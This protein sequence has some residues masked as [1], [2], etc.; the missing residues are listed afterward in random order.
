MTDACILLTFCFSSTNAY[1]TNLS[2]TILQ[3]FKLEQN[4]LGYFFKIKNIDKMSFALKVY[5][6]AILV[7]GI[8]SHRIPIKN[9]W[10]N[11]G[12]EAWAVE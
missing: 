7:K 3:N 5:L 4:L 2:Y 8:R 10:T 12:F 9:D 11:P 1:E 6:L